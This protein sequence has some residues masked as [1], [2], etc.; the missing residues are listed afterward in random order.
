MPEHYYEEQ[1]I[2][3]RKYQ[4]ITK[5]QSKFIDCTFE[6]C[7]FEDCS[8]TGC[9]FVN[10]KFY[11]CNIIS[12]TSKH[13]EMKNAAFHKCNL[14]IRRSRA[15]ISAP[16]YDTDDAAHSKM[17]RIIHVKQFPDSFYGAAFPVIKP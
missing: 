17:Q 14:K 13:S 12:L 4:N 3:D 6:N 9:V 10:C 16:Q 15:K 1:V 11:K 7:S 2:K 8:I 5:E